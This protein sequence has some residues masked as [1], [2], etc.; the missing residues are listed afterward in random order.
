MAEK[1]A[2]IYSI[3]I[4]SRMKTKKGMGTRDVRK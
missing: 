1:G 4:G 3:D 2:R